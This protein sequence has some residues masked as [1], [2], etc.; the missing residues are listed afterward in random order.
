[1]HHDSEYLIIA[2][3]ADSQVEST[4]RIHVGGYQKEGSLIVLLLPLA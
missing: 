3:T 4:I 2:A 1:M